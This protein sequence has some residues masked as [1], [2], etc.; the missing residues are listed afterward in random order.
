[1]MKEEGREVPFGTYTGKAKSS[2]VESSLHDDEIRIQR[3][4]VRH[5]K[6]GSTLKYVLNKKFATQKL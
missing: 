1:M 2:F 6:D 5:D 3:R 4:L